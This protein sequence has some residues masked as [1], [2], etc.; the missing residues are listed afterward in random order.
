MKFGWIITSVLHG[1][2]IVAA[3]FSFGAG[4]PLELDNVVPVEVEI[5]SIAP[6]EQVGTKKTKDL[7]TKLAAKQPIEKIVEKPVPK[8]KPKL[9]KPKPTPKPKDKPK[10]EP[11]PSIEKLIEEVADL[12]PQ[13]PE[14]SF[15]NVASAPK[16]AKR[17]TL[18][19]TEPKELPKAEKKPEPEPLDDSKIAALL[20][21]LE[22]KPLEEIELDFG[23][24]EAGSLDGDLLED[25]EVA[26]L[27]QFEFNAVKNRM[28][29]CWSIPAGAQDA[30]SVVV[31]VG[32]KLNQF[33]E[34]LGTPQVLNSSTHPSFQVMAESAVRAIIECGPYDMLPAEKFEVWS[35][36]TMEFDPRSMFDG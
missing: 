24:I 21:K 34:V 7:T 32:F 36:F 12:E 13:K 11:I 20:D 8:P 26:S 28:T 35:E 17:P 3:I 4:T 1:T 27:S 18:P 15:I 23:D 16:P 5:I 2:I 19:K 14:E 10:T 9:D 29:Q 6:I 33:A 22:E 30:G 25:V 31:K